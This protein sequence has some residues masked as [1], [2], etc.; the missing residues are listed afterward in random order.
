M[1]RQPILFPFQ[2]G[3]PVSFRYLPG[4]IPDAVNSD[5]ALPFHE[6]IAIFRV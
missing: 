5:Y 2:G 1:P 6:K 4:F 3:F